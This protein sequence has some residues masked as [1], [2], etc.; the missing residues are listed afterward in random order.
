MENIEKNDSRLTSLLMQEMGRIPHVNI[1]G[2][3]DSAKHSG[4]VTFTV[5]GVHP[6]DIATL[7]D[8][9]KI[10]IRAGHHCAQPLG[11]YLELPATARVSVYIYNDENDVER[12]SK[13]LKE[14]RK[15]SGYKD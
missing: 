1:L 10:A 6:H 8:T 15:M 5:D 3:E 12:F 4:I 11:A 2:S 14:I 7:L 9:E 13:A